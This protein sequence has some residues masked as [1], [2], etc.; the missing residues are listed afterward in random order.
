MPPQ[1]AGLAD[2]LAVI[3]TRFLLL[4][5]RDGQRPRAVQQFLKSPSGLGCQTQSERAVCVGMELLR[6][7]LA[8]GLDHRAIDQM[9]KRLLQVGGQRGE[10]AVRDV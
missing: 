8:R 5:A 10:P 3:R 4:A 6:T 1:R 9:P 2:E 7:Q